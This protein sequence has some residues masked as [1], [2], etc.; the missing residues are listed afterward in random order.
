MAPLVENPNAPSP[1]GWTPIALAARYGHVKIVELL[2]PLVD[3]L[4]ALIM[5]PQG[6]TPIALAAINGHDKIIE[7]LAPLVDNPNEPILNGRTPIALAALNGHVK[8][9]AFLATLYIRK[10]RKKSFMFITGMLTLSVCI[11]ATLSL[12]HNSK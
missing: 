11:P 6:W 3:N 12:I 1:N 2:A 9:A 7:F 4:N 5:L 8:I 10:N